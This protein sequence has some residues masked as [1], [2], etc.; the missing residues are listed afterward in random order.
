MEVYKSRVLVLSLFSTS[1]QKIT[2]LLLV[3][4]IVESVTL[5]WKGKYKCVKGVSD[6]EGLGNH[7][8]L[9]SKER[10]YGSVNR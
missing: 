5:K 4:F 2:A 7:R 9:R 1:L 10:F 6:D 3:T 8:N